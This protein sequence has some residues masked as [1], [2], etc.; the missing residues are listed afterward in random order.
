MRLISIILMYKLSV[1][2]I[3]KIIT[4]LLFSLIFSTVLSQTGEIELYTELQKAEKRLDSIYLSL[5]KNL[6][7]VEKNN[8]KKAQY[9]WYKFR[10]SN[11][12]FK[13]LKT[14]EGGVIT[15][16]MFI[17]CQIQATD[18]RIRE[19]NDILLSGF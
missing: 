11:C 19:L 6:S 4:P 17:D 14:S 3:H 15:N 7:E 18:I 13:S 12:N 9:L 8:L 10:D 5:E 2:L 1:K 16:K